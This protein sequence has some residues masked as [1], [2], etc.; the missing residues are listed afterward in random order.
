MLREDCPKIVLSGSAKKLLELAANEFELAIAKWRSDYELLIEAW[1]G[2][3]G[4]NPGN[5]RQA[6][7][8]YYQLNTLSDVTVIE[9][10][11]DLQVLPRYGFPIGLSRLRVV[12]ANNGKHDGPMREEDQ[13]RLER[14]GLMALREYVP[15]SRLMAGGRVVTS[16]GLLKHWTGGDIDNGFG[17]RGVTGQC[18]NNHRCY[19]ISKELNECPLCS[20]P[21][22]APQEPILIPKHGYTTAAWDPPRFRYDAEVVGHVNRQTLAFRG[23]VAELIEKSDFGGIPQLVARYRQ[24]G[25]ILVTNSGSKSKG[26][27]LCTK[28]G[29]AESETERGQGQMH[30]PTGFER[31]ASLFSNNAKRWCWPEG[32]APVLRNQTLAASYT[33]DIL[34]VDWSPWLHYAAPNHRE[35]HEAI[36][37]ALLLSGARVLD[38][39]ASFSPAQRFQPAGLAR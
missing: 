7:A 21:I 6:N 20:Q 29:Y 10:L 1:I 5:L 15:G 34:L 18:A 19:S 14:S 31:H 32:Q 16:R 37:A 23:E 9:T 26:F 25:E 28:C 27:A 8:L 39:E 22:Q 30:L 33:T 36:A 13:L 17:L 3:D 38:L 24:D 4:S 2:L 11:A 35:I 12:A